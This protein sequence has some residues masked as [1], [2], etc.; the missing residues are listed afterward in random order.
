MQSHDSSPIWADWR[1]IQVAHKSHEGANEHDSDIDQELSK[2]DFVIDDD[3]LG[4]LHASHVRAAQALTGLAALLEKLLV[5]A[6][7][8]NDVAAPGDDVE[9]RPSED[10]GSDATG[11]EYKPGDHDRKRKVKRAE[12]MLDQLDTAFRN[13][14]TEALQQQVSEKAVPL[15]LN[16]PSAAFAYVLLH[17]Q[18]PRRLELDSGHTVAHEIRK[19]LREAFSIDGM[20]LGGSYGWL[21]RAWASERCRPQLDESLQSNG[22]MSELIAF[23]AAGLA[24]NGPVRQ[25]DAIAQGIL[26]G[27]HLVTGRVPGD[28]FGGE[29]RDRLAAVS[30]SSGGIF[31]LPELEAVIASFAPE[32]LT[33]V[34]SVLC[35]KL[36]TAIDAADAD[37][38]RVSEEIT[39]LRSLAPRFGPNTCQFEHG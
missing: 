29:L 13:A 27:L 20:A 39:E 15:L 10:E 18:C 4:A 21:V 8:V 38:I 33:V 14:V 32:E 23:V 19:I 7:E 22:I 30:Q 17:A 36:L 5:A 35:W 16:L 1:T 31:E 28:S 2:L 3:A 25:G 11:S 12:E 6:D 24:F 37:P 26:A 9:E 34:S